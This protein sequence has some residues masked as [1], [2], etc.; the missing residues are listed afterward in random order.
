MTTCMGKNLRTARRTRGWTQRQVG[1]AI[2]VTNRD[3]SRWESGKVEPGRR[4]RHLLADLLF[5]GDLSAMYAKPSEA[6]A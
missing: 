4:Y 3:V 2:G 6:A 1:E 5:D